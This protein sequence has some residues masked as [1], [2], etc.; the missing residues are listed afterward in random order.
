MTV[1]VIAADLWCLADGNKRLCNKGVRRW[2]EQHGIDYDL[3]LR[4]GLPETAAEGLNDPRLQLVIERARKR[5]EG[6]T[7]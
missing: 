1:R 3:F 7:K 2:C 4:E 5:T 6:A